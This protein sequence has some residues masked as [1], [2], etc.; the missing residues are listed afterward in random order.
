M[1]MCLAVVAACAWA[2]P[3]ES[4]PSWRPFTRAMEGRDA[5]AALREA[6]RLIEEDPRDP[7]A[8]YALVR[9]FALAGDT[10]GAADALRGAL[11]RGFVDF[12]RLLHDETMAGLLADEL[13]V[14]LMENWRAR[15]DER[16]RVE[17]E[18]LLGALGS[19]YR[20]IE[21]AES[22]LRLLT[23]LD[24]EDVSVAREEL[25]RVAGFASGLFSEASDDRPDPWVLVLIPRAEDA[26]RLLPQRNAAGV[27]DHA[28]KALVVRDIGAA[29][30][31]EWFHALHW[32]H[33]E[34][35]GRFHPVWVREGLATLVED[36]DLREEEL[37]VLGSWRTN[38]ARRLA[39]VG[40]LR[41]WDR[42]VG[43]TG[44]RFT[45]TTP[46]IHYAQARAL[47]HW[48]HDR[49]ELTS[50][51]ALYDEASVEDP[52]GL[53]SV[54][55]ATG[56]DERGW[57]R[58]LRAWLLEQPAV[59]APDARRPLGLGLPLRAGEG[60]VPVIDRSGVVSDD[61][62]RLRM[63]DAIV[64]VDGTPVRTV[65]ELYRTVGELAEG[66]LVRVVLD[67]RGETVEA[68]FRV[69]REEETLGLR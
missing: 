47:V 67:R 5:G 6:E 11:S 62:V 34:R 41:P 59:G 28:R 38:T 37:V 61:G 7:F 15:Q 54:S 24:D 46:V 36:V 64:S 3:E 8:R 51:F 48:L 33:M 22:R 9:A 14:W 45:R 63:R 2:S 20:L 65:H 60:G 21:D 43:L 19:G 42:F 55:R 25:E 40:R 56:M 26:D 10:E 52:G 44:E 50:W 27:Y 69:R 12:H 57:G 29:L 16:A 49:G 17:A 53:A 32:R 35:T 4:D 23:A 13:G 1:V 66:E 31:H 30:R 58:A 39:E 18:A 68:V